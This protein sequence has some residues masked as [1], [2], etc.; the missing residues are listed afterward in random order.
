MAR[1]FYKQGDKWFYAD[2]NQ[3]ILNIPELQAAQEAGGQETPAPETQETVDKLYAD[4]AAKNPVIAEVMTGGS[5]AEEIINAFSTGDL[6]G[7]VK[8][9]GQPFTPEE[10]QAA[11]VQAEEANK[12]F[13]EQQQ[14]KA[15]A[16]AEADLA[17]KQGDY[18]DYLIQSGQS[19]Q[20]DKTKSDKEAADSGVLFS[21]SRVQREKNLKRAYQQ[22]QDTAQRNMSNSIGSTAQDFQYKYGDDAAKGLSKSYN[23]GSNTFNANKARG[24]VGSGGLASVYNPN[25]YKF[26]G[27]KKTE[28]ETANKTR[29]AGYLWNKGNK[30][31]ATGNQNQFN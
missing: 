27:T 4:A 13:Y 26:Y 1:N 6:S 2:N 14:A 31:M 18:Q 29:A 28:Q 11:L 24:G 15:T 17:K 20:A 23:L 3:Q 12:A 5:S 30:L 25:K 8:G 9:D 7:I 21:G 22:D 10:H 19:F 16:D